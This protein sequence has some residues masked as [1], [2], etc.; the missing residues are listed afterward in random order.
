MMAPLDLLAD[1]MFLLAEQKQP[2]KGIVAVLHVRRVAVRVA[3][4]VADNAEELREHPRLVPEVMLLKVGRQPE[5]DGLGPQRPRLVQRQLGFLPHDGGVQRAGRDVLRGQ[6]LAVGLI[7]PR[8]AVRPGRRTG[9]RR[10]G[11]R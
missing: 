4:P 3:Q 8:E 5:G 7:E 6:H 9:S 11:E 1:G 2:G 10:L